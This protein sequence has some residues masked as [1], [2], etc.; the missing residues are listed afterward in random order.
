MTALVHDVEHRLSSTNNYI[1][2]QKKI[3]DDLS[4][5]AMSRQRR[6]QIRRM[7][8]GLCI[9][10][11]KQAFEETVWCLDHHIKR[12]TRRPGRNRLRMKKWTIV[13]GGQTYYP[14]Y[15]NG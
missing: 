11:G 8:Q 15:L 12:G 1:P 3:I 14:V 9:L 6:Y 13:P 4:S 2:M 7:R 5:S 10:C